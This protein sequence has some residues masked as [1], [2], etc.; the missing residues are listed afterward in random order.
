[1]IFVVKRF[2]LGF[3]LITLAVGFLLFSD[4]NR[5]SDSRQVIPRVAI[6]Q[7]ASQPV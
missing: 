3:C 4:W 7:H 6:L 1:M 5:R 2:A